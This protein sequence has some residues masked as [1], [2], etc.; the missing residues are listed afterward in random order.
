MGLLSKIVLVWIP[1]WVKVPY[2]YDIGILVNE[3]EAFL[4]LEVHCM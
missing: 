2:L 3:F 1:I 4:C